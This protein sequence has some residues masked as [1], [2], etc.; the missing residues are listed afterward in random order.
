M[1]LQLLPYKPR[2][3]VVVSLVFGL[4]TTVRGLIEHDSVGRAIT[5]GAISAVLVFLLSSWQCANPSLS[6]AV[7]GF[8]GR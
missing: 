2:G 4:S 5:F 1:N 6:F 8:G 7:E 3:A